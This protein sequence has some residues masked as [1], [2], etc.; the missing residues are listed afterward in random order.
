MI[1]LVLSGTAREDK[2][3]TRLPYLGRIGRAKDQG[4]RNV[5]QNKS[6]HEEKR[7]I[8]GINSDN[9]ESDDG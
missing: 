3:A 5:S 2:D 6:S 8:K 4:K 7:K 1:H 9:S